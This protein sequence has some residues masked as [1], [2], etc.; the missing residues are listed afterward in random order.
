MK[1]ADYTDQIQKALKAVAELNIPTHLEPVAFGYLLGMPSPEQKVVRQ[2]SGVGSEVR[3][4][5]TTSDLR[6]FISSITL[7]GAVTEIPALLYW[8]RANEGK[9]AVNERDV[10]ELYRRAGMRPPKDVT[11]SFR[12]LCK[13]KYFRLEPVDGARGHYRLSRAGEDFVLHDLILK[14]K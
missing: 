4:L 8:A 13:K 14:S 11:Q 10:I 7:K 6:A 9:D 12:D 1:D 2:S 5:N 3:D